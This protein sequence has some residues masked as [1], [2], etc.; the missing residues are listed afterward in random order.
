MISKIVSGGQTG[1]DR[2]ALDAALENNFPI[3][4]Y[5]PGNRMAEDGPIDKKYNLAEID[6]GYPQ[7]T[8]MNVE[9][10]DGT[11]IFYQ[12]DLAGGTEQTLAFCIHAQKPY[13]LID[14]DLA[15]EETAAGI[16]LEFIEKN[17]IGVV[18]VAGPRLSECPPIYGFVK[19]TIKLV[20]S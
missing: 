14:I 15:S 18:N 5:C 1:A 7:R 16:I 4:G 3:G 13:K 17:S 6:G 10:S 9:N 8:R 20:F 2:A 11:L 19:N 12:A